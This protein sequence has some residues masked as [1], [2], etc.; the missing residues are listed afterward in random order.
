MESLFR[1]LDLEGEIVP[2]P[3]GGEGQDGGMKRSRAKELRNNPTDAER[4]LWQ[5]LRR[6]QLGGNKFRRQQPL[7]NYIVD[8][9]CLEKRL[10]IEVDGGQHY[11]QAA[12]D[13][14]CSAWI[15]SQGFRVLRFWDDEVMK[16]IESVKEVIWRALR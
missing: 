2:S 6:R 3:L 14:Q 10:V 1:D 7:G 15:E 12:Y 16:D 11:T 4:M 13:E 9:A 5:H 8:F